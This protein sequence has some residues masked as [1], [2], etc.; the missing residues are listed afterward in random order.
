M[1]SSQHDQQEQV[2]PEEDSIRD[3]QHEGE[4]SGLIGEQLPSFCR[5]Q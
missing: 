5:G 1:S 2:S 3:N 4:D